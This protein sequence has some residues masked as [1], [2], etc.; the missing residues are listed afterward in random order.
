MRIP[1]DLAETL[2]IIVDEGT[3][4]AAARRL[5]VTQPA[6]SQRL[7]TLESLVGRVLLVRSRPVRATAAG[8]AVVRYG[9]QI[10]HLEADALTELGL[11]ANGRASL[12]IAVNSDSLATWFLPALGHLAAEYPVTFDLRRDDQDFTV[13]MLEAGTVLGAVTSRAD[14]IAGCRVTPLGAMRYTPVATV[15]F[16]EQWFPD[17]ATADAL[18]DAPLVDFDSRD[19]LQTSW[20][21]ARGVDPSAPPR[22]RVPASSEFAQAVLM[23][24]GWGQ[25]L[26][27]Q[28]EA[29]LA[30]GEV[31]ALDGSHLDVPLYWQQWNVRSTLLDAV[32]AEIVAQAHRTLVAAPSA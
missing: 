10:A 3:L 28:L 15:A 32:G 25:L 9:R 1:P 16:H 5:R 4:E 26:P 6:V 14:P 11:A 30:A 17:G 24:L 2:A 19:D 7:R 12:P 20:L 23:G 18:R 22:H 8:E 27:F 21:V 29:P 13:G 31:R